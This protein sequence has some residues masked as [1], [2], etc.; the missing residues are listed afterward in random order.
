MILINDL[1][2]TI[3]NSDRHDTWEFALGAGDE[4]GSAQ[5]PG[6]WEAQGYDLYMEGPAHYRR[7][8]VIPADWAGQRIEIEFGAVSYACEVFCN[9]VP[10]GSHLGM[11][12]PFSV[13]LTS[14]ARPGQENQIELVIYKPGQRYPMRSCLAGFLP[15]VASTFGGPW[16]PARLRAMQFGLSDVR[17]QADYAS[18]SIRVQAHLARFV[19][20]QR[21]VGWKVTAAYG[22]QVAASRE[23]PP[24][25]LDHV[26]ITLAPDEKRCWSPEHPH[27]CTVTI[28]CRLG[29]QWVA[30]AQRRVGFRRLA[31]RG[32]QLL[33][34]DEPLMARGILSWGWDPATI[35]PWYT[36]ESARAEMRRVRAM[37]FNLIKLCLFVPNQAYF[38]IADE[39]GMLLWEELPMWLP[40]VSPDLRA[41]APREY[42]EIM[43]MV[44]PHPSVVLYSL[45]CELNQSVDGP[46]LERLNQVVRAQVQDVLLCDNSGSGE[47]Y[48][49]LDFDL[50]DFTDYHPYYDLH[51]FTPLLDAWRRDWQV[52]R[53]WIFGEFCDSDSFRDQDEITRAL[54]GERPWW[55]TG[56]NPVTTW[57][58]ESRAAVEWH[59][60]LGQANPGFSLSEM[61]AI[62]QRQSFVIRKYTLEA[63]RRRKSMGGYIITGL[64]DTPISTSGV[65]D[66]LMRPK[67]GEEEFLQVN[68]ETVLCLD[69]ARRR[70][71]QHGGDRP[72][73]IDA[74]AWWAGAPARWDVI[75][76]S[77][78]Q[79][80]PAGG[81]LEWTITTLEGERVAVGSSACETGFGAGSPAR[82]GVIH[83]QTPALPRA[84]GFRLVVDMAA[85]G[86]HARN[87]WTIWVYPR[88]V[89]PPAG[90][91]LY[92][93]TGLL[94]DAGHWLSTARRLRPWDRFDPTRLVVAA[95]FNAQTSLEHEP[96]LWDFIAQGGRVLLLQQG[97]GPLPARRCPFWRE[98]IKLFADHALWQQF[99][100][101]GF[102][103]LQFLGVASDLAF[104]TP[105]LLES[106]PPG[107]DFHPILRRLDAREFHI[108]EY[109]L[110]VSCGKG[111][112]LGCALRL[113]GGAGAQPAGWN[114]NVSGA[115]LLDALIHHLAQ[116][117]SGTLP[118]P[119]SNPPGSDAPNLHKPL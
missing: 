54:G 95:T 82:I 119:D 80:V 52:E 97:E 59:E 84:A 37:G 11:W 63:L 87:A 15:D 34:N 9:D 22:D 78:R 55:L 105:R 3:P 114:R 23:I 76:H 100:H 101:Q 79:A 18:A 77:A 73:P 14:A 91:D 51:Y 30:V 61:A 81:S 96:G 86:I 24:S 110:E 50:S 39:E 94:D 111:R 98:A 68:G 70:R 85:G 7:A 116:P 31:A 29:D 108:S 99:P 43:A 56:R 38:E 92:D 102:T 36:P 89:N 67:W 13:D 1:A 40:E 58:P 118:P 48:G 62:S 109:L 6:C 25:N 12:T 65:W 46:L 17:V 83:W 107:A 5:T 33:L 93:P 10:V 104:D 16:Q 21:P 4:H 2:E 117:E 27:L 26:D 35:A 74:Y 113:Q 42:E 71:W 41:R 8:V 32:D 19:P 103:D 60:R 49:G 106:L 64:R 28:A 47:S 72:D 57:R 88:P 115:A 112:L 75:L 66:D 53:P 69:V 20:D 44:A 45:G 90:M